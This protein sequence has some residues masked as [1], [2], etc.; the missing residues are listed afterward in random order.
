MQESNRQSSDFQNHLFT[1][2]T[3]HS[4]RLKSTRDLNTSQPLQLSKSHRMQ[5]EKQPSAGAGSRPHQ[6]FKSGSHVTNTVQ[7]AKAGN[8]QKKVTKRS[9]SKKRASMNTSIQ[10]HK[11]K[12]PSAIHQKN[13]QAISNAG[14]GQRAVTGF[15]HS[16]EAQLNSAL[17]RNYLNDGELTL[18]DASANADNF[19]I[20]P[21][22]SFAVDRKNKSLLFEIREGPNGALEPVPQLTG[23]ELHSSN[24]ERHGSGSLP[25]QVHEP[26]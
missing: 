8:A 10:N 14:K 15:M 17:N 21:Q 11:S 3:A 26:V 23:Y 25:R 6:Q 19:Q 5:I 9:T 13:Y 7:S 22:Q 16:N 4:P 2:H 12:S 1:Q 18:G 24:V 20:K